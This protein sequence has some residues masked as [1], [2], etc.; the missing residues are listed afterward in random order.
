MICM[1]MC[2]CSV[3]MGMC[4]CFRDLVL[5]VKW[6]LWMCSVGLQLARCTVL[7]RWVFN[8]MKK[9]FQRLGESYTHTVP[10]HSTQLKG[11]V[12]REPKTFEKQYEGGNKTGTLRGLPDIG[13]AQ[14]DRIDA[15]A[16]QSHRKT[17]K[18]KTLPAHSLLVICGRT[19]P[20]PCP[21]PA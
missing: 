8:T 1:C 17:I 6:Y 14:T 19:A 20:E 2:M 18:T 11:D 9:T 13:H 21:S 16:L 12:Q 15:S 3:R 7:A 10:G 5:Y 4:V